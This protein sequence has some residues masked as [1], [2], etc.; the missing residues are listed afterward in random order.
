MLSSTEQETQYGIN[1]RYKFAWV[2]RPG[3][4]QFLDLAQDPGE[5]DNLIDDPGR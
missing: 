5:Y 1:G 2:A 3:N 4:E